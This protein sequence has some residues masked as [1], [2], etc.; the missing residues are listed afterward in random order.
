MNYLIAWSFLHRFDPLDMDCLAATVAFATAFGFSLAWQFQELDDT[1]LDIFTDIGWPDLEDSTLSFDNV[2]IFKDADSDPFLAS[3][4]DA[5]GDQMLLSKH[6]VRDNGVCLNKEPTSGWF[7]I[8]NIF[9]EKPQ[10]LEPPEE[11]ARGPNKDGYY[12]KC[13]LKYRF[14]LCCEGPVWGLDFS[15]VW[16]KIE[17]CYASMSLTM[18][19]LGQLFAIGCSRI[20]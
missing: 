7:K 16:D 12:D 18:L 13:S 11:Q 15:F 4:C 19:L 9:G 8:P 1:S 17:N 3:V 6:R 5:G 20:E 2:D 14:N 10:P